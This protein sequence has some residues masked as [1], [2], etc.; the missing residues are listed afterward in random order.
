M[1]SNLV[2]SQ[3]K[4]L[5]SKVGHMRYLDP[6]VPELSWEGA[7]R[8]LS[9]NNMEVETAFYV[10]QCDWLKPLYEFIFDENNKNIL[11]N[12]T[13]MEEIKNIITNEDVGIEVSPSYFR[14]HTSTHPLQSR[15]RLLM[16]ECKFPTEEAA[17]IVFKLLEEVEAFDDVSYPLQ[18]YIEAAKDHGDIDK[19]RSF[20]IKE[21]EICVT[22]YPVHE[23]RGWCT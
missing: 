12:Q 14:P 16:A 3:V 9:S 22:E 8:I 7:V 5:L 11:V 17:N 4:E 19:A 2:L 6:N 1:C 21:C 15:K 10:L 18:Y 20:L 23:V 13:E